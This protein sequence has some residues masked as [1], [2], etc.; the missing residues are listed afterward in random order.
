M[1]PAIE[2]PSG[3][4]VPDMRSPVFAVPPWVSLPGFLA[5]HLAARNSMT[6]EGLPYSIEAH[7][8]SPTGVASTSLM[9]SGPRSE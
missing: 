7:S 5:P 1:V 6:V 8:T 9:T 4:L 2:N 3:E